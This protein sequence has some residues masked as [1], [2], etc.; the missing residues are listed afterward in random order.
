[1][2]WVIWLKKSRKIV[3]QANGTE[4]TNAHPWFQELYCSFIFPVH[5]DLKAGLAERSK[6]II[7]SKKERDT[8]TA[9]C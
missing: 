9:K 6:K 4:S 2:R 3:I 1:M 5:G 7:G 8:N